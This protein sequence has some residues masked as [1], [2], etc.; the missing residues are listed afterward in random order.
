M[1]KVI[2]GLVIAVPLLFLMFKVSASVFGILFSETDQSS[3][4]YFF[5]TFV[6]YYGGCKEVDAIGCSCGAF[7]YEM[8]SKD[9]KIKFEQ[10]GKDTVITLFFKENQNVVGEEIL[11]K[12]NILCTYYPLAKPEKRVKVLDKLEIEKRGEYP[13]EATSY[14]YDGNIFLMKYNESYTCFPEVVLPVYYNEFMKVPLCKGEI[15]K[16]TEI[17][18]VEKVV[19]EELIVV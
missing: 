8:L 4:N 16:K 13:I 11:I 7:N 5:N 18:Q 17:E 15:D 6:E 19:E 2:I 9:Y 12:D 14:T 10:K 3:T 1:T